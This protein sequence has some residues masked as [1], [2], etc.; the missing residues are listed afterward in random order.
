MNV[1]IERKFLVAN[2]TWMDKVI[3]SKSILQWYISSDD[4]SCVRVRIEDGEAIICIKSILTGISRHEFHFP[5]PIDTAHA[6]LQ[7]PKL[8]KGTPITKVR[9]IVMNG[10]D[11]WEIDQFGGDNA[12]LVVAE[13]ELAT[14]SQSFEL[15]EWLGQQVTH[16]HRYLNSSLAQA[17]YRYWGSDPNGPLG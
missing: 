10:G 4:N 2:H 5:I 11:R 8:V 9:H 15:P 3:E 12:G 14:E 17:P 7:D 13:L 6:M 1:E 16:D